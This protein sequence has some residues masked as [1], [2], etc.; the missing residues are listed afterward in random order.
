MLRDIGVRAAWSGAGAGNAAAAVAQGGRRHAS[1][2]V[3]PVLASVVFVPS[4]PLLVPQLA[5]P[6]AV[7]TA[8]VR[9]ATVAAATRLAGVTTDWVAIGAD[10]PNPAAA[11]NLPVPRPVESF[12]G[13]GTF[14][15]FGVDVPVRL[16][17]GAVPGSGAETP[18]ATVAETRPLPLSMLVAAWLRGLA[19][20]TRACPVVVDPDTAPAVCADVGR[21]LAARIDATATPIGV[22]VV[23]DG[24][25][26]LTPKAPGGGRREPAVR[27][28]QRID[29]AFAAADAEALAALDPDAC[30]ESG[31]AG[32]PAWQVA[33][34]LV[35][36]HRL[37]ADVGYAAAPFGVGY[38]V[39]TWTP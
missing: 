32:R 17:S 23:A 25:S 20:A 7:D 19:G 35:A 15:R 3:E 31:V 36:G 4:A 21:D 11:E 18:P 2:S 6:G 9:D 27:L 8:P 16:A 28:Q 29:D 12:A 13:T 5:G 39:A 38:T 33:A 22:L 1:T 10:D 26:A 24:A 30:G 37:R 14:A 34:A